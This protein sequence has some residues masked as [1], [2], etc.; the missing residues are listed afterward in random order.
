MKIFLVQLGLE[1]KRVSVPTTFPVCFSN[2][3]SDTDSLRD[4]FEDVNES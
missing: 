2:W 3:I 4:E 1:E